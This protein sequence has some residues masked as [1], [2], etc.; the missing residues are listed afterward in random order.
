MVYLNDIDGD[1]RLL[2][3]RWIIIQ[4]DNSH[5]NCYIVYLMVGK[6]EWG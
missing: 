5:Y 3:Y 1:V 6:A 4:I 2:K